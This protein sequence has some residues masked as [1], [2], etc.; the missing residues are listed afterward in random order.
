[1]NREIKFRAWD[2]KANRFTNYQIGIFDD[3]VRFYDKHIGTW[4]NAGERFELMMSTRIKDEEGNIIFEND[5]ITVNKQHVVA[6]IHQDDYY[7][8]VVKFDGLEFYL[9]ILK[10][11]HLG[12]RPSKVNGVDVYWMTETLRLPL[13]YFNVEEPSDFKILG[14]VYENKEILDE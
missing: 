3:S 2:K 9:K 13:N 6:G 14:N 4:Y 7:T 11:E 5:I 8:G 10:E 1:M 12:N